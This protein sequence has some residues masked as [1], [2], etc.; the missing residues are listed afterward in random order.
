MVIFTLVNGDLR[1]ASSPKK[2]FI[3]QNGK[4]AIPYTQNSIAFY[5]EP[6]DFNYQGLKNQ[7]ENNYDNFLRSNIDN[8]QDNRNFEKEEGRDMLPFRT[9]EGNSISSSN[10]VI[11][12]SIGK[13]TLIP[14]RWNNP[15]SSECEINI[16]IK[17]N[18]GNYIV[19]PIKK[20]SCC[21]EGYQ[22]NIISFN[23]PNDFNQLPSKVPG[24]LGCNKIGDCTLQIYAH[25]V[26]PR[27]YSIGTPLIINGSSPVEDTYIPATDNSQ[28]FP[29]TVDP[30][31]NF[32]C[33]LNDVCLP[34][35]DIKSNILNAIPRFAR[36]VSDQFNHAYQN[37]NFSPYSGQQ[38]ESISKNLQ[39]ATIL[40]M[41]AANGGELGKSILNDDDKNFIEDL[42]NNVNIVVE[43]YEKAANNIFNMI[44]NDYK[45]AD[46]IGDQQLADCFRCSDTGS[47][48]TKRLEQKTYIPSF[49][50]LNTSQA[51]N[52]RNMLNNNVKNLIPYNSNV[53][54]IYK[55]A[56]NEL[57]EKFNAAA[58]RG[59][60]YQPAMIKQYI[61]T[62]YDITNFLKVDGNGNKDNGVFA[63]L[64]AIKTKKENIL[65]IKNLFLPDKYQYTTTIPS[66]IPT[67][68]ILNE[69]TTPTSTSDNNVTLPPN[70]DDLPQIPN[71]NFCGQTY[72]TVSCNKPCP[73]GLDN[74]CDMDYC[75]ST[76]NVC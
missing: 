34:T 36:L 53:V 38:H 3:V 69:N 21:A 39:A 46:M 40:R 73:S 19:I 31:L 24:F 23:I 33:L 61:T 64:S 71:L 75:F 48:N 27:T 52:I 59:F 17:N 72:E 4:N 25:S 42:I 56:L 16:W 12:T 43:K 14:L 44:K 28:I 63:S 29:M 55:A 30:Q 15:H 58:L 50:I 62:M 5:M 57:S 18:Q 67:T 9:Y 32:D 37:S 74:E 60:I 7:R 11:N 26:E 54:Q 66:N 35:T 68:A 47:V 76:S 1:M 70:P 65:K 8:E 51:N 2:N 41:T 22:D 6:S 13:E 20:P 49:I 45:R 10:I